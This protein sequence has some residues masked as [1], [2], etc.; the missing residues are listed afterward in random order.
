MPD[1]VTSL[2]LKRINNE[3]DHY[4]QQYERVSDQI[5]RT[6]NEA[7]KIPLK[8]HLVQIER[9]IA[10]LEEERR[11]LESNDSP[12]RQPE[13]PKPT[14]S[15]KKRGTGWLTL[16][17]VLT[18]T[19]VALSL[20]WPQAWKYFSFPEPTPTA[21][22]ALV[23][24]AT[25][26]LTATL[27][28]SPIPTVTPEP[29][30]P[31]AGATWTEPT[32][33]MEFV[34]VPGGCFQM[35][36]TETE[37][38]QLIAEVGEDNY[39]SW[40]ADELSRR[41]V[42]VKSFDIGKYEVTNAQY[43]RFKAEH[44][45]KDYNGESLNGDNQPVVS[46][47]WNEAIAFTEWLTKNSGG[48]ATFR[49]PTEAEWEY[50]ARAGTEKIRYWGDDPKH[51]NACFYANVGDAA[52]AKVFPTVVEQWKKDYMWFVHACD[53]G[54]AVT[55][56]VGK[57]KPNALGLYDM[58]GNVWEWCQDSYASYSE[59]PTD[60]S[61]YGRKDD[62]KVKLLR[63]GSWVAHPYGVRGAYRFRSGTDNQSVSIGFRVVVVR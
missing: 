35:G 36:Q 62:G 14:A 33:G 19:G 27:T 13:E 8:E 47:S 50:A 11:Q 38:A 3:I 30:E 7:D 46:V 22:V 43:R 44:D 53:D 54:Y 9:E 52:L 60:G 37:K 2:K 61:A 28:K 18:L 57:F 24:K 23:P 29:A 1:T 56:P 59:T 15:P 39:K 48:T 32:T 58:L 51:D 5:L 10:R 45:S 6:L 20:T 42:C 63:G 12:V 31:Q 21:V 26:E 17:G 16:F 25:P 34:Y 41:N 49:L 55:S 40:Y 4:S